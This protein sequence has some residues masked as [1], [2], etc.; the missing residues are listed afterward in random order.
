MILAG[1]GNRIEGESVLGRDDRAHER[2]PVK[3]AAL[4]HRKVVILAATGF[5]VLGLAVAGCGGGDDEE[6]APPPAAPA[7]TANGATTELDV[8]ADAGGQLKFDKTELTAPAGKVV[9]HF[10]NDSDV[11]HNLSVEDGGVEV[12]GET[13]QG[14]GT[15]DTVLDDLAPGTYTFYCSVPGHEAAGM[16]G[17]LTIT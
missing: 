16:K 2:K 13:F 3:G 1:S 8:A 5:A 4:F 15:K 7:E 10:T 11:P 9:I 6:A 12:E 17:V 14:G